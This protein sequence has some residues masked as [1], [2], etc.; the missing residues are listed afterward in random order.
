MRHSFTRIIQALSSIDPVTAGPLDAGSLEDGITAYWAGD[1][2]EALRILRPIA[3]QGNAYTHTVLGN[4]CEYGQGVEQDNVLAHMWF[5]LAAAQGDTY[6]A[7]WRDAVAEK[8]TP[9]QIAE[10]Q[11]LAGEW[12]AAHP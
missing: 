7:T 3:E 2:A 12:L 11:K 1:F 4:M 9:G 5:S 8:M 10:G 6:G